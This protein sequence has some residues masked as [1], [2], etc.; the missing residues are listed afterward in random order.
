M[1]I[2]NLLDLPSVLPPWFFWR[3]VVGC[4]LRRPGVPSPSAFLA[5]PLP[6]ASIMHHVDFEIFSS[7][8]RSSIEICVCG[9]ANP[10]QRMPRTLLRL[11]RFECSLHKSSTRL[12]NA[13][14]RP[15]TAHTPP[16]IP[17]RPPAHRPIRST[18]A[19]GDYET[20]EKGN[21]QRV[22]PQPQRIARIRRA[23][24]RLCVVMFWWGG[25][26]VDAGRCTIIIHNITSLQ[27]TC[28]RLCACPVLA[29]G[30]SLCSARSRVDLKLWDKKS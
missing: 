15:P 28:L 11:G 5:L 24:P 12:G 2:L 18:V 25:V 1:V 30:D 10:E 22:E 16:P 17:H 4:W 6:L 9:E 14:M 13:T 7:N 8:S 29:A 21:A 26:V 23:Q 27:R 3:F 19:N 20:I